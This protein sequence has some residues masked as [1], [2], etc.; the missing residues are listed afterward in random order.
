MSWSF[1]FRARKVNPVVHKHHSETTLNDPDLD[2]PNI[3]NMQFGSSVS[4]SPSQLH[5]DVMKMLDIRQVA[6]GWRKLCQG[7]S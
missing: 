7:K 2:P 3:Y 5:G 4:I 1:G 6:T